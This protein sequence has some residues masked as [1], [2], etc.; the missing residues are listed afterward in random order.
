M[1]VL[2]FGKVSPQ[3]TGLKLIVNEKTQS[4]LTMNIDDKLMADL[5]PYISRFVKTK[6]RIKSKVIQNA[7]I[8]KIDSI[9]YT[10]PDP[11]FNRKHLKIIKS[12]IECN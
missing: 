2:F 8:I 12:D 6:L 9:D 1:Q 7:P 11:L 3:K 10:V 5:A 4:Q